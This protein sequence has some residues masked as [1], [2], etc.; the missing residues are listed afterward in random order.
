MPEEKKC[1]IYTR[2]HTL[3]QNESLERQ[4]ECLRQYAEQQGFTVVGETSDLDSVRTE[5]QNHSFDVL[6]VS[7][8]S[9]IGRNTESVLSV[10]DSLSASGQTV[11]SVK[12]GIITPPFYKAAFMLAAAFQEMEAG[13]EAPEDEE[14][15]SC[16]PEESRT[17]EFS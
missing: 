8:L 3:F 2:T 5:A 4:R 15:L 11:H 7:A 9:Q 16:E 17:M 1:L 13:A 6:A 14:A 12:E 10:L